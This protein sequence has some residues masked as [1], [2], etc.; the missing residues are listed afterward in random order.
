[1]EGHQ[2]FNPVAVN[3]DQMR[4]IKKQRKENI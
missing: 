1:M 4:I 2:K 3:L